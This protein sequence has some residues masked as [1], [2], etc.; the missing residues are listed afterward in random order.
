MPSDDTCSELSVNIALIRLTCFATSLILFLRFLLLLAPI[1]MPHAVYFH[2]QHRQLHGATDDTPPRVLL[3][4]PD[5]FHPS[6][7]FTAVL[8]TGRGYP[9]GLPLMCMAVTR[10]ERVPLMVQ[11]SVV[12]AWFSHHV[13]RPFR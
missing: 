8:L 13:T 3:G 2:H 5:R 7:A 11:G 1:T 4:I 12:V 6:T 10:G 9:F